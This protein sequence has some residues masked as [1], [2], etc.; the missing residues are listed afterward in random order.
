MGEGKLHQSPKAT[1]VE[2]KNCQ[3]NWGKVAP[4]SSPFG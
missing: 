3:L 4:P 2:A 1:I